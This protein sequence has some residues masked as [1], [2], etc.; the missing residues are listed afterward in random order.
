MVRAELGPD[1]DWELAPQPILV[2][3]ILSPSTRRRDATV[4]RE[5]YAEVG[6][7]DYWIVDP[8]DRS[9]TVVRPGEPDRTVHHTLRWEPGGAVAPFELDVPEISSRRSSTSSAA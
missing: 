5:L 9:I 1:D 2:V 6:I 8:T 7:P 3:E 4:K